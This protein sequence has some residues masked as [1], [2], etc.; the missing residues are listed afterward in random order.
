M[1]EEEWQSL[2]IF[3][4]DKFTNDPFVRDMDIKVESVEPKRAV[5]SLD[6]KH[7]RSNMFGIVHGGVLM[8]LADV[9][10]G[11]ACFS[12]NKKVVTLEANMSF[13]RSA[14]VGKHLIATGS[15]L[16]NGNRT[17]SCECDITDDEGR[18]CARG[19]G[20]FFVVGRIQEER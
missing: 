18:L 2:K 8:T 9:G 19:R 16:H 10:M 1:T 6:V 3:V 13:L 12:C 17:L 7:N 20:T 14:P 5:F 15:V 11:A 4:I